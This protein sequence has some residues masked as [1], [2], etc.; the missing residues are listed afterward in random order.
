MALALK[1]AESTKQRAENKEQI[2]VG[3]RY[4]PMVM[5]MTMTMAMAVSGGAS[6]HDRRVGQAATRW[7]VQVEGPQFEG[8]ANRHEGRLNSKVGQAAT[9]ADSI[10]NVKCP[11]LQAGLNLAR[12][13]P[14]TTP[15]T[16]QFH[17]RADS[18]LPVP[19]NPIRQE[20]DATTHQE[21][22]AGES[23]NQG[24]PYGGTHCTWGSG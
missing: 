9:R 8:G 18:I 24:S 16:C 3:G 14:R 7:D 19:V 1:H 4:G 6:R 17:A 21:D 12:H 22:D 15:C 2:S 5:M 11:F 13:A 10:R 20:E 23:G